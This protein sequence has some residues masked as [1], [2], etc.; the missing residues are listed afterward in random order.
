LLFDHVKRTP[1]PRVGRVHPTRGLSRRGAWALLAIG[2]S[3]VGYQ[4]RVAAKDAPVLTAM[5][6]LAG[7]YPRFG[8]RMVM[9]FLA[10][11]QQ[12][13]GTVAS[14]RGHESATAP[15][16]NGDQSRVGRAPH[17]ERK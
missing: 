5:R 8:Y 10:R 1:A 13:M 7:Q 3:W 17:F 2:R 14:P 12:V 6:T 11:Q 9:P 16:G 4:S 15:A